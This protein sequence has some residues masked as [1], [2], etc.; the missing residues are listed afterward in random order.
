MK[1]SKL[2][3]IAI[4]FLLFFTTC[5]KPVPPPP[6]TFGPLPQERQIAWHEMGFYMFI[7]FNM[8]TFTN[9]EWGY[10][11]EKPE[12]FN[13]TEL[14]T[15]QWARIAKEAGMKGIILTAK[16]HDGFCLWPS[17]YT[18]H[19]VKNSKWKD[20]K[21]DVLKDLSE[22]CAAYGLKMGVYLSPWDRNHAAYGTPEYVTCF[23]N[24]LRELLT[25]YGEIFEVWFDGANGGDGYYG[26]ARET[27]KI[28]NKTYYQWEK[29]H[30]IVRELQPN[31][32]IFGDGGP[33]V[34]WVGN[35]EGWANETNWSLLR[36]EKVY[37]GYAKYKELRSGHE[38]GTHW[39]PAECDVSIRPGWYYHPY[40]DHKVKSLAH[41]TDIYY[42]SIGRNAS[43]L[44]NFPVDNRG[45]IHEKD[46]QQVMKLA[47]VIKV[48]FAN[49][50]ALNKSATASETRG[51][52][53][54]YAAQNT[55]DANPETYWTTEDHTHAAT[56]EIDLG[57]TQNVNRVLLQEY[58]KLG[59]RVE[60]Y[61]IDALVKD[62][63]VV[64]D[65]GTTIGYKRIFRFPTVQTSKLKINILKSKACPVISNIEVYHAPLLLVPPVL[66]RDKNGQV[67]IKAA[68]EEAIV[69]YTIDGTVPDK[70]SPVYNQPFTQIK[71][72]ILQAIAYDTD[73]RSSEI[74]RSDF[75]IIK[76]DWKVVSITTG[77]IE[78][79]E[80]MLDE[81]HWSTFDSGESKRP[82]ET[83][84]DL[85]NVYPL[86]GFTYLPMQHRYSHG[87]AT[88]Y[89]F[90]VSPDGKRWG[91]AVAKGEFSNI[92]NSPVLQEVAFKEKSGRFIQFKILNSTDEKGKV[93]VAELGVVTL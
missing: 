58:I 25:N 38:D 82:H 29:A 11:D 33:E 90:F 4:T 68:N 51:N 56:L 31:A 57:N 41:L 66:K 54:E 61:T 47:E 76:K 22:A 45:L 73:N 15:R 79:A 13:P 93:T 89:E 37:P 83:V 77:K 36:K 48:D 19:S 69:H 70:N 63:W 86:K 67:T 34:R 7:H 62:Q 5:Q 52:A 78:D 30:E 26:G 53:A 88:Q 35:E 43:L 12:Q 28:D 46:E 23:H 16:H 2:L 50:L 17:K 84:I 40:E 92:V 85:G 60:E 55:T 3:L 64:I 10:G 74:A 18:E 81:D 20:G 9:M 24:Q 91:E 65:T 39:V 6:Q 32:C 8:N 14:D 21:G 49:N 42:K 27:R 44:L 72:F 1:K 75:D 71:P 80:K 87:H 59:Q